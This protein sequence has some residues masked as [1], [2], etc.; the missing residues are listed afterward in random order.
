MKVCL[1]YSYDWAFWGR[2]DCDIRGKTL[3]LLASGPTVIPA[4]CTDP[5]QGLS[6]LICKVEIIL[7]DLLLFPAL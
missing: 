7:S 1:P 2:R 3:D 5:L 4:N 6:F